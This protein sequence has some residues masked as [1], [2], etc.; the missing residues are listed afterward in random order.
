MGRAKHSAEQWSRWIDQQRGSGLTSAPR[1]APRYR[2]SQL[3][4]CTVYG[5]SRIMSICPRCSFSRSGQSNGTSC[6]TSRS[7]SESQ[8]WTVASVC[9]DPPRAR[10]SS[11]SLLASTANS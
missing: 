3:I 8:F 10:L 4:E 1:R 2:K 7:Y 5:P 6:I 11:E 9:H